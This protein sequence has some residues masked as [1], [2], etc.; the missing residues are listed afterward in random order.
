[1]A[2]ATNIIRRPG[3]ANYY[4]RTVVPLDVQ[5]SV[6]RREIWKSLGTPDPAEAKRR[7]RLEMD[8]LDREW[9]AIRASAK[10]EPSDIE[11][12]VWRRYNEIIEA[13]ERF[14][15]ALP[16]DDELDQIWR[17]LVEEYGDYNLEA[18]GIL[19]ALQERAVEDRKARMARLSA[20]KS[21]IVKNN[22]APVAEIAAS[23]LPARGKHVDK[24]APEYKRLANGLIRAEVEA[25]SRTVERDHGDYT[26]APR[27]PIVR[28][29]KHEPVAAPGET[30]L[31]L[32]ERYADENVDAIKA[33]TLHQARQAVELFVDFVGRKFAVASLDRKVVSKWRALLLKYPVK[34]S[35]TKAFAGMGLIQ[36]IE[37]NE[38]IKKP[39]ITKRTVNRY[40]SGLGA[41]CKW[42]VNSGY[43]SSSPVSDM[44]L[45]VSKKS[46]K[47]PFTVEQMNK[48]FSEAPLFRGCLS[49]DK[50][51]YPG[52]VQIRDHR[53]WEPL[54]MLF[55]GCRPAEIAQLAVSDVR[56][57]HGVWIMHV[58]ET[59]DDDD[60]FEKSVKTAG[61][62]RIVPVHSELIKLGFID[63]C[64]QQADGGETR[65]FPEAKRNTRGQLAAQFSRDFTRKVLKSVGMSAPGKLSLYS[66]RH[67]FIDALRRAGYLDEQF[68]FLVGHAKAST[69]GLYGIIPQGVLKQRVEIIEKVS[70][71]GLDIS[72][73]YVK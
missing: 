50:I 4:L 65:V 71:T 67:G 59:D 49:D 69:T 11:Q 22:P 19:R 51:G 24:S 45:S 72:H 26:G 12:A 17:F 6:G 31:E 16:N 63:F 34:A 73:L 7:G 37:A 62:R 70:Y 46:S 28:P 39:V 40:L 52:N 56:Q 55:S 23:V 30:L 15:T 47:I 36:I 42:L 1:M 2:L 18:Y 53:Y 14:R 57:E 33:D 32:F 25:L 68:G 13:D 35:E 64:K 66:F 60:E 21:A 44:H 38:K 3:S 10:I 54:V 27:D 48:L 29:P 8:K 58:V 20:L 9:Q 5:Q 43:I 41:F 61:S